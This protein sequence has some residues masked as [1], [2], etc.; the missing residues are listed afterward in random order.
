MSE[1][2]YT[3]KDLRRAVASEMQ[4]PFFRRFPAGEL[5]MDS[6]ST[7]ET[8]KDAS[9]TQ[10]DDFWSGAWFYG[11]EE[12]DVSYIR[13]YQQADHRFYLETALASS[14][15][16]GDKYEI[17]TLWSPV[18]VHNAINQAIESVNRIYT[19]VVIDSSLVLQEDKLTY[20]ISGLPYTP[21]FVHKVFVENPGNV[22][23]GTATAG[24]V[25]Y[26]DVQ[27]V[28]T[29]ISTN[30][31]IA[32]YDGTGRGQI[33]NYASH[34][35]LQITPNTNW[36]TAPSATSKYAMWDST[37]ELYDWVAINNFY[38]DK[39]EYPDTL[40]FRNRPYAYYGMRI[41]I[42]YSAVPAALLTDSSTTTV[43]KQYILLKACSY[44]HGLKLKNTKADRDMHY[45]EM[46][47]YQEEAEVYLQR[48]LPHRQDNTWM[49][50]A[51]GMDYPED[52]NGNPL[53][54]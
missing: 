45:A 49:R 29:D 11:L 13:A 17:H 50:S 22:E 53:G 41:K 35:G 33:R 7:T 3:L 26:I 16:A 4:M 39:K 43:P 51:P 36:T 10:P 44:L 15:S 14:P 32:I 25:A 46:K 37:E 23:R 42:E 40:Y 6:G 9:L 30:W 27:S 34:V 19:T 28:P 52:E 24:N 12:E 38:V 1:T 48:N 21:V 5:A 31:K 8:I 54:W 18:E 47:R 20:D 2:T